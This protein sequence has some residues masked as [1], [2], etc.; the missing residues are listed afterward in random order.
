MPQRRA[1]TRSSWICAGSW[2][3]GKN[4]PENRNSGVIPNRQI[5]LNAVGVAL[6]RHVGRD[7]RRER[8]RRSASRPGSRARCPAIGA[9]PNS[10]ITSAKIAATSVGAGRDPG[11]LPE[12][13]RVRRQRRRV[14]RVV[15]PVPAGTRRAPGT[16]PRTPS[17]ASTVD[18]SS[19]GARNCEVR[20]AAAGRPGRPGRRRPEADAHRDQEQDRLGEVAEDRAAPGPPVEQ[21]HVLVRGQRAADGARARDGAPAPGRSARTRRRSRR[22]AVSRPGSGR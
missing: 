1:A 10:R 5:A 14:H 19:A 11:D 2:S 18:T 6:G 3:I 7:R 17:P 15:A 12:R 16:W 21:P 22:R 9:A 13:D 8:E 20:H 4:V